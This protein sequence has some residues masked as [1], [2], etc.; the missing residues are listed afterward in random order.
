MLINCKIIYISHNIESE[1][2]KEYSNRLIYFLTKFLENLVYKISDYST[3]VSIKEKEKI[4]KLYKKNV[5]IV[6]ESNRFQI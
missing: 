2:K 5:P 6:Y 4:F 3:A 1:I